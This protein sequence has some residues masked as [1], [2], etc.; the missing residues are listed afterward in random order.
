MFPHIG[1]SA[2]K[3]PPVQGIQRDRR[4]CHEKQLGALSFFRA[5]RNLAGRLSGGAK[6]PRRRDVANSGSKRMA[7]DPR[8]PQR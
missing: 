5:S 4:A 2:V 8:K 6:R 1:I 7:E 3:T